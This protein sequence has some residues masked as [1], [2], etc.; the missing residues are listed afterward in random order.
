MFPLSNV[1]LRTSITHSSLFGFYRQM[2]PRQINQ[3]LR[4]THLSNQNVHVVLRGMP[5]W[6][7]CSMLLIGDRSS[8]GLSGGPSSVGLLRS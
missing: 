5:V 1:K 7:D 3:L 4:E 2:D 8:V 6:S